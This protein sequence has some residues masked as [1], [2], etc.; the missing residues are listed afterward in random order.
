V[1]EPHLDSTKSAGFKV[2][3]F[4]LLFAVLMYLVKQRV[5]RKVEH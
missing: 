5:W 3:A 2:L 4:L 1:A